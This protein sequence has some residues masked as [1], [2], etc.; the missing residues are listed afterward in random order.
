M[1]V[2]IIP[3]HDDPAC[4]AMRGLLTIADAADASAIAALQNAVAAELTARHGVGH[5]SSVMTEKGVRA[6]MKRASVFVVRDDR[7]VAATLTLATRK[8][9]AIDRTY[10][11]A[12]VRPVYLLS[13]AVNPARQR[14]GI[15]RACV[16]EAI[17]L[18][19]DWPAD[20][21]CL[22]AYDAAAGA[23]DFYRKC[24]FTEVGRADYRGTPLIYFERLV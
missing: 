9:W 2:T 3:T 7:D 6:S 1:A 8:P 4:G 15:G 23:G 22:D 21:V 20:A 16:A 11:T 24:G 17:D 5:W 10:F 19:R 12:V 13:M 18:V 14:T